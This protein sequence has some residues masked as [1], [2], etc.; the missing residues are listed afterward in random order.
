MRAPPCK[1]LSTLYCA[2][3]VASTSRLTTAAHHC[4]QPG[5]SPT[6]PS[7]RMPTEGIHHLALHRSRPPWSS[8]P[9]SPRMETTTNAE[10]QGFHLQE[11]IP[12][13]DVAMIPCRLTQSS[14]GPSPASRPQRQPSVD[15]LCQPWFTTTNLSYR[16]PIFGHFRHCLVRYY[17]YLYVY[18]VYIYIYIC[19]YIYM[20]VDQFFLSGNGHSSRIKMI[21]SRNFRELHVNL[22]R[23]PCWPTTPLMKIRSP[24]AKLRQR[25]TDHFLIAF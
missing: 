4:S 5:V 8:A 20:V 7:R 25:I 24:P 12:G 19:N 21:L 3:S 16:F 11:S 22:S 17:G 18:H 2:N 10:S 14:P 23:G 15:S 1:S 6:A 13:L 9:I